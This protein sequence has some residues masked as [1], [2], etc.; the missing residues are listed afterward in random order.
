MSI[1]IIITF[2]KMINILIFK[3]KKN[4]NSFI[5]LPIYIFANVLYR[6]YFYQF[7]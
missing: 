4:E 6:T 1:N 5:I 7:M 2:E 3:L